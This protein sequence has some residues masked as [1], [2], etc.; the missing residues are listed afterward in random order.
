MGEW[1]ATSRLRLIGG[2]RVENARIAV[3]SLLIGNNRNEALLENTDVLPSLVANYQLRDGQALRVSATQ[4]LARPEYRELSPVLTREVL[5]GFNQ[6]GNA[7]LRR[8]LIQNFDAKWEWYPDGGE[9]VS[10]GVFAKRFDDP[11]ERV[12]Q[13]TSEAPQV[14]WAN[15]E[16][17][18]NYGVELELR[19]Q[20]GGLHQALSPLLAFANVTLMQSEITLGDSARAS[21][22]NASRAMV[23]QAPWVVNT[24]L[25]YAPGSGT[26]SATLLYNVV[27]P[28]ITTAGVTPAPRHRGPAAPRDRPLAALPDLRRAHRARGRA[29]PHRRGLRAAPG[30]GDHRALPGGADLLGGAVLA[31]VGMG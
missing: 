26:T 25:T 2:A 29:Q 28:R 8:S 20:L 6:F 30:A 22:T 31:A 27:G 7:N 15:A 23:G 14:T 4:T 1:A 3:T 13:V 18:R 16:S 19:K 11:I 21:L 17:A 5:G 10:V 12:Q 9:V 24:G